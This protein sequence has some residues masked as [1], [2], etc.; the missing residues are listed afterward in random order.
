MTENRVDE[1][2]NWSNVGH[3]VSDEKFWSQC[4]AKKYRC[5]AMN[6]GRNNRE[7]GYHI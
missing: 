5:K 3:L 2:D 1:S 6:S 7:V 4:F